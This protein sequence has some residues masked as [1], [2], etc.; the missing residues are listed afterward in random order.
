MGAAGSPCRWAAACARVALGLNLRRAHGAAW[1][2]WGCAP[3]AAWGAWGVRWALNDTAW[4]LAAA[5]ARWRASAA[6]SA[7]TAAAP[8]LENVLQQ[9]AALRLQRHEPLLGGHGCWRGRRS[10]AARRKV[11]TAGAAGAVA[12]GTLRPRA[13]NWRASRRPR[14]QPGGASRPTS[15]M[16]AVRGQKLVAGP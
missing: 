2:A 9:R 11:S 15:F 8:H 12:R 13:P 14:A 16:L 7:A 10:A 5:D 6:A 1:G 4:A 3:C